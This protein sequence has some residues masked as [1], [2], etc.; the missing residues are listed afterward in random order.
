MSEKTKRYLNLGSV[1]QFSSDGKEDTPFIS[2]DNSVLKEFVEYLQE[3]GAKHLKGL[4]V[5]EI[6]ANKKLPRVRINYYNPNEKAPAFVKKNLA[7]K[8]EE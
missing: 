4:T 8:L 3:F 1:L 2:L 7:I 6:R 5:E